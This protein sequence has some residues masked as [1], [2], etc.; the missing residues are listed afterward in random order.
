MLDLMRQLINL[1]NDLEVL[2]T[3]LRHE[4]EYF[5]QELDHVYFEL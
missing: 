4:H 2:V 1:V 3:F 5:L